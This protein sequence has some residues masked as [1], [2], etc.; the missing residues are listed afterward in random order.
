M[1]NGID[2]QI[3]ETC[4]T[5]QTGGPYRSSLKFQMWLQRYV[6]NH[7]FF[8]WFIPHIKMV[9]TWGWLMTLLLKKND[10]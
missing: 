4:G 6:I 3:S 2:S 9:M 5:A 8:S 10:I 1:A 7:R